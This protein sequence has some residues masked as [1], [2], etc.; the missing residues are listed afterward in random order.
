MAINWGAALGAA[1]KT[2][3]DTYER[4][5]EEE[6]REMQRSQ[7]RKK[8]EGEKAYA[9]ALA[10]ETKI[11]DFSKATQGQAVGQVA[12]SALNF[13]P[14]Q[15][16]EFK[17]GLGKLSEEQQQNVLR[18]Y[19]GTEYVKPAQVGEAGAAIPDLANIN[20]Y[21]GAGDQALATTEKGELRSQ[22]DIYRGVVQRLAES[23]NPEQIKTALEMKNLTR[24]S[25]IDD[26]YDALTK[27]RDQ[28][29]F[30]VKNTIQTKGLSGV[31]DVINP[32]L[33][34][35][36]LTAKFNEKTGAINIV[37]D[38]GK[39]VKAF[40]DTDSAMK[41]ATAAI[42][43]EWTSRLE[44]LLGGA[45]KALSYQLSREKNELAKRELDIK[46]PYYAAAAQSARA[47]AK[48]AGARGTPIAISKDGKQMFMSNGTTMAIPEGFSKED[49]F[50]KTTG[51]K[52]VPTLNKQQEIA[53]REVV[54][55]LT[56]RETDTDL[57]RIAKKSN[58]PP[59]IFGLDDLSP[60][61]RAIMD[62]G[63]DLF[64]NKK[65]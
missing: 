4:L 54:K 24:Q 25:E 10:E 45:D 48:A 55:N 29:L 27:W 23:G 7:L 15:M 64:K 16:A 62:M 49:F 33:K 12:E 30:N 19:A 14:E 46:E 32:E 58:L 43:Q 42:G 61:D 3:I 31:P 34:K 35:Q 20:V 11:R 37:D 18:A 6:L 8:I 36:G 63:D 44:G 51:E 13:T 2:G 22:A 26:K 50:P 38:K 59:S 5:G 28:S 65:K 40:T 9:A 52:P 17:A 39:V 47:S 60:T 53:Y 57:R 41:A 1:F 56:G 21:K